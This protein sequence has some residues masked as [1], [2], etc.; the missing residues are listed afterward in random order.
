MS[1]LPQTDP[2]TDFL[3]ESTLSIVEAAHNLAA[4]FYNQNAS[5]NALPI[6]QYLSV[7]NENPTVSNL[8]FSTREAF[9]SVVNASLDAIASE[10]PKLGERFSMRIPIGIGREGVTFQNGQFV[11]TP[12]TPVTTVT[13]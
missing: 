12:P 13:E 10:S 9:A 11:Y 3:K 2:V 1:L 6:E 4:Q 5:L 8:R 7:I